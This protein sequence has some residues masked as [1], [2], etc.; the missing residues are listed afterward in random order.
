MKKIL[1]ATL[2]LALCLSFVSCVPFASKNDINYGEK[3]VYKDKSEN[4]D[5]NAELIFNKDGTGTYNYFYKYDSSNDNSDYTTSG[6]VSFVWEKTSDNAIHLFETEVKYNDD[7]TENYK[8]KLITEPLYFSENMIY[9]SYL[10]NSLS[11]THAATK[12]FLL[13][14]SDLY[15]EVY[16]KD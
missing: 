16:N 10:S 12:K 9:Y 3:Y 14:G 1:T 11:S 13:E 6:T 7:H 8:I 4:Y 2:L 15:N 5:T